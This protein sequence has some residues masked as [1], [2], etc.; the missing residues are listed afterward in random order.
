MIPVRL[1]QNNIEVSR[2]ILDCGVE[3][4]IDG[5]HLD[6]RGDEKC[7]REIVRQAVEMFGHE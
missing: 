5:D 3:F 7:A 6:Y 4:V 1:Q 2:K